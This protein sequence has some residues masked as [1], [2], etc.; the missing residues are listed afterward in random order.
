MEN[1][2]QVRDVKSDIILKVKKLDPLAILP[3][4]GS[5][6]AAGYDLFNFGVFY[7]PPGERLLI[8]TGISIALSTDTYGRIA[9][10]SSLS[11]KGIDVGAGVIDCDYRGEIKVLLINNSKDVFVIQPNTRIAQLIIER[12]YT[13]PVVEVLELDS[14]NRGEGGFGSTG[15]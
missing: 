5:E 13:P 15:I 1:N 10:R 9:S 6:Y 2:V 7:I 12:I 8:N 4:R 11:L 3:K 14:T